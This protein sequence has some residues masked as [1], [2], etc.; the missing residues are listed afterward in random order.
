MKQGNKIKHEQITSYNHSVLYF[1]VHVCVNVP[2]EVISSPEAV[3]LPSMWQENSTVL[4]Y[5]SDDIAHELEG[6]TKEN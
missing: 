2:Q 5:P 4:P 3:Q 1:V 6:E